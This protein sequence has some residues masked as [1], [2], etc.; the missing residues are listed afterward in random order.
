MIT[1]PMIGWMPKLGSS[2]GK[3][4]SYSIYKYGFRNDSDVWMPDAGNGISVTNN[5]PI[6]WNDR[7]DANF[8]YQLHFP[9]RPMCNTSP[10]AGR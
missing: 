6:T 2:R 9:G 10:T 1:I 5:T 8:L 3:L 7:N 4:A